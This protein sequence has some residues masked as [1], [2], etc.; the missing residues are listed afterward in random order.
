MQ[1]YSTE[2]I[3]NVVL[4]SH[5][6]AGKTSLS[7][8]ML[9]NTGLITRLGRVEEGTT[10][11]DF[12]PD[13]IKRHISI[14]T[15]IIP[16]EWKGHKINLLDSPGYADFVGEVKAALRVA[17]MAIL[18]V[19]A[20]SGVEVGTE[21]TWRYAEEHNIP[22]LVLLNKMDR[23]NADFFNTLRQVNEVL[24]NKCVPIQL[25]IGSQSS[26]QGVIDLL[27]EKAIGAKG[28]EIPIPSEMEATVAE[29]KEKLIESIA[30]TNDDLLAKYLE[31][32]P[33]SNE[34]ISAA[35]K[36]AII[37][38]V[39]YPVVVASGIQNIGVSTLMDTIVAL[40][41]S[42]LE[43]REIEAKDPQN[44]EEKK[45]KSDPNG[46]LGAF[47][48]KTTADQYV[49]KLTYFRVFSGILSSDSHVW[50][51]TKAKSERLGQLFIARGKAQEPVQRLIAGD[52]GAVAKLADTNTGDTL[53]VKEHPIVVS[54]VDLPE[55]LFSVAINPKTKADL[56]KMG[57]GLSRLVEE[58]PTLHVQR[59]HVTHETV[60]YGIGESHIDVA[61]EKLKRKFGVEVLATVPKVAYK[62]TITVPV[63]A[64][65][66][67][68][69]QTG[70]HGQYGHVLLELQPL[71]R[72]SGLEFTEKVVGGSV[73]KN[74]IAAVEKGVH[75][76]ALEGV[77]GRFPMVDVRAVLYDGSYHPVDSSDMSFQI[78][79]LHAFRKGAQEGQPVL[80]EPIMNVEV[81]VPAAFMGDA[82]SDL[83]GKR[84]KVHGMNTMGGVS[85]VEAQAPLSEMLRY[86]TDLRSFTQGRGTFTMEFSHYEPVPGHLVSKIVEQAK[87][88]AVS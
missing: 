40:G 67:H 69:K 86:A 54:T 7:E 87:K 53:T 55:P 82:I 88:E 41:P 81:T 51:Q 10:T 18:V 35:L 52:I 42:P 57:A 1:K 25:P 11:S 26:F 62:E 22:R 64:E 6:G 44:G 74:Y 68:K 4:I 56:D 45:L 60:L 15:S 43:A 58:D 33:L 8:A 20:A 5:G 73:P 76:A 72:G 3:R 16:C 34:E 70:G 32:E 46:P 80:L 61:V 9:F 14:S 71:P 21:M 13:E 79:G 38:G 66:K 30:E 27:S 75:E 49:G 28:E 12:D 24:S 39:L 85:I 48:F 47:V 37:G 29:Y 31:G 59:D 19:C 36:Q 77:L 63:K 2:Q 78:A 17:D 65:Y 23:D 50:N 84:A 83:N